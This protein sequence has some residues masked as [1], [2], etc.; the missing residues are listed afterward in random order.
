MKIFWSWASV[1]ESTGLISIHPYLGSGWIYEIPTQHLEVYQ[2]P[3]SFQF[4]PGHLSLLKHLLSFTG[5]QPTFLDLASITVGKAAPNSELIFLGLPVLNL[6]PTI[7][8]RLGSSMMPSKRLFSPKVFIVLNGNVSPI[9]HGNVT[10]PL[11]EAKGWC[12]C[13]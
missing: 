12:L 3:P 10:L 5:S 1:P 9:T 6:S 13:F 8:C 7:L 4:T 2:R 11:L